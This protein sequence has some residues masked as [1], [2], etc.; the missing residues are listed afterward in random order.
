M[1]RSGNAKPQVA[2]CLIDIEKQ[3]NKCSLYELAKLIHAHRF[4]TD[5]SMI[6]VS[7]GSHTNFQEGKD[8]CTNPAFAQEAAERGINVLCINFDINWDEI[9][10]TPPPQRKVFLDPSLSTNKLKV[11]KVKHDVT[12]YDLSFNKAL[13]LYC[14]SSLKANKLVIANYMSPFLGADLKKSLLSRINQFI[15]YIETGKII[16]IAGYFARNPCILVDKEVAISDLINGDYKK[17]VHPKL[18]A[19]ASMEIG[20]IEDIEKREAEIKRVI[21]ETNSAP[22]TCFIDIRALPYSAICSVAPD[23]PML[24]SFS[25]YKTGDNGES[26]KPTTL[27]P[28]KAPKG[29]PTSE[30]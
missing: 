16:I 29:K 2:D 13:E 6:V 21:D 5:Q 9:E 7:L 18:L 20:L 26:A 4:S 14:K 24:T 23:G 28:H 25:S 3:G 19:I 8:W 11:F 17:E 30:V 10:P 27:E 15:Q 12:E 22:N 1:Q